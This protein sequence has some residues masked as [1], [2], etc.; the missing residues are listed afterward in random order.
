MWGRDVEYWIDNLEARVKPILYIDRKRRDV[1]ENVLGRTG[2]GGKGGSNGP[3]AYRNQND[4]SRSCDNDN[5][6]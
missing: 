3:R 5:A 4:I 2:A 6:G 1:R